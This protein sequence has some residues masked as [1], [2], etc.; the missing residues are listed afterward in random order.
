MAD[1]YQ[2][3]DSA[4]DLPEPVFAVFSP[5]TPGE[6]DHMD[7]SRAPAAQDVDDVADVPGVDDVAVVGRVV[8]L[9][10]AER[11]YQPPVEPLSPPSP[12]SRSQRRPVSVS[13][14]EQRLQQTLDDLEELHNLPGL[15]Q[16]QQPMD[17]FR[18]M[19]NLVP[20]G[21]EETFL[22]RY[23][24]ITRLPP[25]LRI[26]AMGLINHPNGL[27]AEVVDYLWRFWSSGDPEEVPYRWYRG[28]GSGVVSPPSSRRGGRPR[29]S[30][31]PRR[32]PT[33]PSA[34]PPGSCSLPR[35]YLDCDCWECQFT[36]RR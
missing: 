6:V 8:V 4:D 24:F 7:Y 26:F 21:E 33:A 34:P 30:R 36:V 19:V 27:M 29:R 16:A 11:V 1:P 2:L 23:L 15:Q 35:G 32:A 12:P 17:L 14:L 18:A 22:F 25:R 9:N 31:R 10:P 3:D 5:G 13:R 28:R 20:P